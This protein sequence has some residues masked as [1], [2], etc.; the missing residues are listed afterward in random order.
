MRF[1]WDNS[2]N[3]K[4]ILKHGIDFIDA[5]GAFEDLMLV[6]QD[7][8]RDYG[9]DRFVGLGAMPRPSGNPIVVILIFTL[10][11]ARIRLI[12]ARKANR[13]EIQDYYQAFYFSP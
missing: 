13:R 11:G 3:A 10:R 1:E 7:T 2:K 4:N 5:A 6:R 12:S 8:R 9:E